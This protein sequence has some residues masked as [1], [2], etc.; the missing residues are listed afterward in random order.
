MVHGG[1]LGEGVSEAP[2]DEGVGEIGENLALDDSHELT[3]VLDP[4]VASGQCLAG[5]T[6]PHS[7]ASATPF[8]ISRRL[9]CSYLIDCRSARSRR[10]FE[11][12]CSVCGC[13]PARTS[14]DE[15][16]EGVGLVSRA[17]VRDDDERLD[18]TGLFG[19]AVLGKGRPDQ[20]LCLGKGHR[21]SGDGVLGGL[22]VIDRIMA[23][24]GG[25]GSY[26]GSGRQAACDCVCIPN[27]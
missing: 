24:A 21:Q 7:F 10:L 1:E 11:A 16:G 27:R 5:G 13:G 26:S 6:I 12:I 2:V 4:V 23:P 25:V 18:L 22:C 15:S 3:F 17:V 20:S 9:R 19:D 14:P 8:G